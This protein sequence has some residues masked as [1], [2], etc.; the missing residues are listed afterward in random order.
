MNK[1]LGDS[2]Q[3]QNITSEMKKCER[4]S[5]NCQARFLSMLGLKVNS[6]AT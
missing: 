6:H 3:S 5:K 1:D 4:L 2:L